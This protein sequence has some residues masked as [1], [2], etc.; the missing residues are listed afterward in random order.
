MAPQP[1]SGIKVLDF[2]T[3]LPGPLAGLILAEA[4][5]QVLKIERPGAGEEMRADKPRWGREAITFA[6]LNRGKYS[7]ALN[8]KDRNSLSLI[9]PLIEE[10]DVLLEQFRPGVMDRLGLGYQALARVNPK[11]IYCSITGYGQT[12]PKADVAAH[13][14]NYIADTGLLGLSFGSPDKPVVPPAL[15]AD[16]AGGSYPAVV[17][18]LLALLQRQQT[19]K[20]SHLDIAM[21]DNLFTLMFAAFGEG[22]VTGTW[23]DNGAGRLTGGSPRYQ[24]YATADGGFVACGALEQ[25]FWDRY[26]ELIELPDELRDDQKDPA[27]TRAEVARL[28]AA[29]PARHWQRR[30]FGE[31]CCCNILKSLPDALRDQHFISRG[32]FDPL[33]EN[34]DGETIPALVVPIVRQFRADPDT[35]KR[36]PALG[37]HNDTI[38]K[39]G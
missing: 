26:C 21:T 38:L 28:I 16:I 12:G 37:S 20:G 9:K 1:L 10:A 34:E 8:L 15:M 23:P 3:L 4:G 29:K 19:G 11:L 7:L 2:S 31:D 25:K 5:A 6:L 39:G 30:F 22:A 36:A 17:N 27:A 13:D 14:L 33:L 18:I 35:P 24:L 32:L